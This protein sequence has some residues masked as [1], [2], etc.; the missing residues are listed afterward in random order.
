MYDY[1]MN[2]REDVRNYFNENES[3]YKG[4][5]KDELQE[6]LNDDCWVSDSVTGNASGSYFCNASKADNALNGNRE[7][8]IDALDEFGGHYKQALL[9][10]EYADV[11]IRCYLLGGQ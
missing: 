6:R 10:A 1:E 3:R 11:T 8:L 9:S 7:L 4:L 5:D 2:L